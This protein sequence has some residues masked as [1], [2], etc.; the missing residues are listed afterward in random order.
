MSDPSIDPAGINAS[1]FVQECETC[2]PARA[3]L[4][5]LVVELRSGADYISLC[6]RSVPQTGGA[7]VGI[8]S[9]PSIAVKCSECHGT[10]EIL[11]L[12]G[13]RI[14]NALARRVGMLLETSKIPF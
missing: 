14:I 13:E 9:T 3:A 6:G 8:I 4:E 5:A 1:L 12:H 11:T 7:V 2:K 10:G